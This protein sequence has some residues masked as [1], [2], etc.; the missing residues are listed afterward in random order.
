MCVNGI[1]FNMASAPTNAECTSSPV[2][3]AFR[4]IVYMVGFVVLI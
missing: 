2:T 4:N 1:E 3:C